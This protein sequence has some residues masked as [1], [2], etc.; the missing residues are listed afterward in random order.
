[1]VK[2]Y[3]DRCQKEV[4]ALDVWNVKACMP[5]R[6]RWE[7]QPWL[8]FELCEECGEEYKNWIKSFFKLT[9]AD[10]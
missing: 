7:E 8:N 2:H 4:G 5:N 6:N 1:M 10:G 9:G 3:C